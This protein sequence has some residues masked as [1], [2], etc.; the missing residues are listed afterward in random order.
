[1]TI[2]GPVRSRL[3]LPTHHL[4]PP[5]ADES[6]SASRCADLD[7]RVKDD[8]RHG[9]SALGRMEGRNQAGPDNFREGFMAGAQTR[10]SCRYREAVP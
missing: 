9:S 7:V 8:R 1:M 2:D 5:A 6:D 4:R 3:S 10:S